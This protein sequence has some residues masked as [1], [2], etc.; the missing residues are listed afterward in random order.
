MI[1]LIFQGETERVVV[2]MKTKIKSK[3]DKDMS[4]GM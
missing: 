1:M 2:L 3:E 4:G